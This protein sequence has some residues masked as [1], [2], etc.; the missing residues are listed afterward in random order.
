MVMGQQGHTVAA[1]CVKQKKI[2]IIWELDFHKKTCVYI[3]FS[4]FW[5]N[6]YA[7]AFTLKS[8]SQGWDVEKVTL[9]QTS[10]STKTTGPT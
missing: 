10:D 8:W 5:G 2:I 7:C 9:R 1:K 3:H 6:F 4:K